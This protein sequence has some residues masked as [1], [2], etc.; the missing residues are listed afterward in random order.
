MMN[1]KVSIIVPVYN[2]EKYLDRCMDSLLN[3]TLKEIEIIMIDDGS[4]DYSPVMCDQYAEKDNRVKVI[5]KKNAGLGFA[6][7]SGLEIAT[8]EYVAFV[9][10]DDFIDIDAF[11]K[12][13]KAA[14]DNEKVDFVMCSYKRIIGDSCIERFEDVSQEYVLEGKDCYNVLAGMIGLDPNSEY[15]FR[16]NYSVWHGIYKNSIFMNKGIRF[17]SER[18]F[19]SE[20]LIFHLDFIPLCGKIVII[21]DPLYNYCLNENSLT[22]KYRTGKFEA[23]MKLWRTAVDKVSIMPIDNMNIRLV[24]LLLDVVLSTISYEVR[25]NK[26]NSLSVIKSIAKNDEV[27]KSLNIYPIRSLSFKH[28]LIFSL[29]KKKCSIWIYI[30]FKMKIYSERLLRIT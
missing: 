29:L 14:V 5:H 21:P 27:Q 3:Q 19:I 25:Y 13:Y 17:Y 16:H 8:G 1:P 12:L 7:N 18:E 30:F 2:V 10:S 6:R 26:H 15:T 24:F 4:P 23:V 11:E 22:T 9:D 20:D 28:F